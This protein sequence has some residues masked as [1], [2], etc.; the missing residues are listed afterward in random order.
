MPGIKISSLGGPVTLSKTDEFPIARGGAT[1]KTNA[2]VL[3]DKIDDTTSKVNALSSNL[4]FPANSDTINLFF[5][6]TTRRLSADLA[7]TLD[8]STRVVILPP[9]IAIPPG[10]VCPF[11]ASTAPI[12]WL[13]CNGNTVPNGPGTV[14]GKTYNFAPLYAV[15]GNTYGGLG[16]LPDLRGQFVRGFGANGSD[17]TVKSGTFG[18]HQK[19]AFQ[20]HKHGLYDPGHFHVLT[21]P[22][23]FHVLTDPGH[24]HVLTDPGHSHG[25]TQ[26]SHK[27]E[28]S[29]LVTGGTYTLSPGLEPFEEEPNRNNRIE[30]TKGAGEFT[31]KADIDIS[32]NSASVNIA[33]TGNPQGAKELTG[34]TA[35]GNPQGTVEYTGFTATGNPQ[36]TV[37]SS[38]V[39]VQNPISDAQNILDPS[40]S[41]GSSGGTAPRTADET[42]PNNVAMLYCIK[43]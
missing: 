28:V 7:S 12:G 10:L 13:E 15:L 39:R 21:D 9:V 6:N 32:I 22:G 41:T 29:K 24:S 19:D 27:H 14:Q 20:G 38:Y 4:L 1:F 43:Y 25:I 30:L 35:T 16:K 42:R 33:A 8:L 37:E 3:F 34:F 2:S 26:Q 40:G 17:P 5:D 23:H 11:A 36:G 18:A 31:D